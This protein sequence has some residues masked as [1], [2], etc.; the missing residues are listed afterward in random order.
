MKITQLKKA[1]RKLKL[2]YKYGDCKRNSDKLKSY[3]NK[4]ESRSGVFLNIDGL[5]PDGHYFY[6]ID[7]Y[8]VDLVLFHQ[9]NPYKLVK[10]C[11]VTKS[12]FRKDCYFNSLNVEA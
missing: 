3:F 2:S 9:K 10:K 11:E 12:I 5:S 8:V 7:N 4:G 6:I 1:I